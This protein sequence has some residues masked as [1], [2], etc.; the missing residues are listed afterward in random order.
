[1]SDNQIQRISFTVYSLI[2]YLC[3]SFVTGIFIIDFRPISIRDYF[4]LGLLFAVFSYIFYPY[5]RSLNIILGLF[6]I[7]HIMIGI[8]DLFNDTFT[9]LLKIFFPIYIKYINNTAPFFTSAICIPVVAY[10]YYYLVFQAG[11]ILSKKYNLKFIFKSSMYALAGLI[12]F[13]KIER[14]AILHTVCDLIILAISLSLNFSKTE[15]SITIIFISVLFSL[16][17]VNTALE[18]LF[19]NSGYEERIKRV[20]DLSAASILVMFIVTSIWW[21]YT[22]FTKLSFLVE[23]GMIIF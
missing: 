6:W 3:G 12:L 7:V 11:Y 20:K 1:M 13:Y 4:L 8:S 19:I 2:I 15:L 10:I 16:E 18:Q 5:K 22:V 21:T 14:K 23:E 9:Y 17:L